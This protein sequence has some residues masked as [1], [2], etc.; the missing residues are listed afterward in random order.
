MT[1]VDDCT[2]ESVLSLD[3]ILLAL[4]EGAAEPL[5]HELLLYERLT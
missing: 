3:D 4:R 2:T 1:V 5:L